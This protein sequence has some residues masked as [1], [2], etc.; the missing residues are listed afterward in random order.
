MDNPTLKMLKALSYCT[1]RPASWEKR[2]VRDLA[3]LGPY[4]LLSLRQQEVVKTLYWR[5]RGQITAL[6]ARYPAAGYP[7]PQKTDR[8]LV[9]EHHETRDDLHDAARV[10]S[11]VV[12]A[13]E[14][15]AA[16]NRK[17]SEK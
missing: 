13:L 16:W 17:A 10:D 2:F 5:Y 4:D 9:N 11:R 14:K 12:A 6:Q 7:T 1:F 8:M 15:L 3:A